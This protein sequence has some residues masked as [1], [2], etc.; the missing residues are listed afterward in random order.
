MSTAFVASPVHERHNIV[1]MVV[2]SELLYGY[3][4][5]IS[6]LYMDILCME[7]VSSFIQSLQMLSFVVG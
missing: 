5:W 7:S 3:S 6:I 4:I 2:I 1:K